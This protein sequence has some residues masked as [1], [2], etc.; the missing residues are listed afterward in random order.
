MTRISLKRAARVRDAVAAYIASMC[1][2][3]HVEMG[4]LSPDAAETVERSRR[5]VVDG[6]ERKA[7]L[8]DAAARLKA[9]VR[10]SETTSGLSDLMEEMDS[11]RRWLESAQAI[12]AECERR[13]PSTIPSSFGDLDAARRATVSVLV[14]GEAEMSSLRRKVA[15]GMAVLADIEEKV[16]SLMLVTEVDVPQE[17]AELL[18]TAGIPI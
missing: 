10:K 18:K 13:P 14:L 3:T 4:L 2:P 1:F 11:G 9:A 8:L 17:D 15:S 5:A 7:A 16:E 12:L 6:L